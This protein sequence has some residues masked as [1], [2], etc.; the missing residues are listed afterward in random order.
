MIASWLRDR[1]RRKLLEH[2]FPRS[3]DQ[4]MDM[5]MPHVRWLSRAERARLQ[6]LVQVFVAE[7][8]WE[9]AG[10]LVLNDEIRV[11][12]AAQACLL[13]LGLE[14]D[15]YRR[16]ESIVIYPSTVVTRR[17][18]PSVLS[19]AVHVV[20]S[21]M[22]IL[23]Q[24]F[25]RGPVILVWDA[26]RSG[27]RDPVDG[28]N[29]VYHEF[30]HKLDMLTGSADGVPPLADR[31]TYQRWVDV[32]TGEYEQLRRQVERRQPTFLDAYALE[33]G[34]EFFAVV[35]ELFFER[36]T[37]MAADHTAMYEVLCAFYHQD[38]AARV[39]SRRT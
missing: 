8:H 25:V 31:A 27:G 20:E 15:L 33:S 1:R 29:V 38:P 34:A 17:R 30:A 5:N 13:I 10:T 2:P 19:T 23:G 28:K 36:P 39:A 32:L 16:V 7:K 21:P 37:E 11:T 14:H 22:P 9:G 4:I 3:W 24:A 35:T 6:E 12:V 18:D 26:V